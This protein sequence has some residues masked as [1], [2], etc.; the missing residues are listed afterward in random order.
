MIAVFTKHKAFRFHPTNHFVFIQNIDSIRG[1]KFT[2]V[3][4]MYG[5][6]EDIEKQEAFDILK[7]KQPE[8]FE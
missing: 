8:L 6:W 3:I 5:F 1:R 2:G 4:E 7:G